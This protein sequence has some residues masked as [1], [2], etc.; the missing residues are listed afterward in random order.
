MKKIFLIVLITGVRDSSENPYRAEIDLVGS[1]V[2]F[3]F[4]SGRLKR[5]A[6]PSNR[7]RKVVLCSDF[8]YGDLRDTPKNIQ[9]LL[10]CNAE[11][12]YIKIKNIL[13]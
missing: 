8:S 6:R 1:A 2:F 3:H 4:G 7:T 10:L 12:Q 13:Q 11:Y 5:I 9:M